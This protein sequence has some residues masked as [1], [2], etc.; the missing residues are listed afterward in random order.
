MNGAFLVRM[1]II[2]ENIDFFFKLKAGFFV[3]RTQRT[4]FVNTVPR[5][6]PKRPG[7]QKGKNINEI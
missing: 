5:R 4:R 3:D 2:L 7:G 1:S 6:F